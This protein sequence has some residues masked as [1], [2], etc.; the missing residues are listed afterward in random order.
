M[1]SLERDAA[2]VGALADPV[3][4]ALYR[5]VIG[6]PGPVS[7]EEA[8]DALDIAHHQAKFHLDRLAAEGLLDIDYA[9]LTGRSG[10][11]AGR[12]AKRYRRAH[13]DI[14]VSLPPRAYELAGRLMA[15]A[16]ADADRTG[17]PVLEVLNRLAHECGRSAAAAAGGGP[18]P[19]AGRAL[20]LAVDVLAEHGYEP[21]FDGDEVYLANCPFHALAQAQTELACA[22]NHALITGVTEALAPHCPQA[23]LC[24]QPNRCCVVLSAPPNSSRPAA[25]L[26]PRT[27]G[28]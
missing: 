25:A 10:P 19:D 22:M 27:A 1:A 11:G 16:I 17:R 24:P 8:A 20:Q 9:R 23:R 14:A 6:Q 2:R 12:T 3:R 15:D 13:R 26:L 5:F 4:R 18:P 7:R 28:R 21:R